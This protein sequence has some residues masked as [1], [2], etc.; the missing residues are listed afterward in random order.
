MANVNWTSNFKMSEVR[1]N[2]ACY[3]KAFRRNLEC[4]GQAES[5]K[6]SVNAFSVA[7]K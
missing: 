1:T 3:R 2:D 6:H 5:T 4:T 7:I